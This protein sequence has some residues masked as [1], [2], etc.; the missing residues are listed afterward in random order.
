MVPM[1]TP[2]LAKSLC[3][4][5]PQRSGAGWPAWQAQVFGSFG[6]EAAMALQALRALLGV[7]FAFPRRHPALPGHASVILLGPRLPAPG[8]GSALAQSRLGSATGTSALYPSQKF[9]LVAASFK[10]G[11]ID[12]ERPAITGTTRRGTLPVLMVIAD[13]RD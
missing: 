6:R 12:A 11:V 13:P 10:H 2:L 8:A 3:I 7:E 9:A 5:D 1:Y 4:V